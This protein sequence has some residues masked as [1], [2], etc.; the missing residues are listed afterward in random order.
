MNDLS[1]DL[2]VVKKENFKKL[3]ELSPEVIL[4]FPDGI[5]KA[6][7]SIWEQYLIDSPFKVAIVAKHHD[8]KDISNIRIPM[9]FNN[10]GV[11]PAQL[12]KIPSIKVF[13]YPTNRA[14]NFNYL[15]KFPHIKHVFIGH[16]DSD[17]LSSSSRFSTVYDF[18]FTADDNAATRFFE[19]G[20]KIPHERFITIGAPVV[21][22]LVVNTEKTVSIKNIL[23]APTSEGKAADSN[24]SSLM[25][26]NPAETLENL[27]LSFN[28]DYRPHPGAGERLPE[29]KSLSKVLKLLYSKNLSKEQSYNNA[30]LIICDISGVMSEF[31][32]TN[33]PIILPYNPKSK[34]I[35]ENINKS[36]FKE[37]VYLFDISKDNLHELISKISQ[38]DHLREAR[39]KA[40]NAKF[41][42]AMS[43]H[44]AAKN[45]SN[46][47]QYVLNN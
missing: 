20:V 2:Q 31:L 4:I 19:R 9:F 47:I 35:T 12:L 38:N 45:F 29:Y 13:L 15:N 27:S 11:G 26:I 6:W 23:F 30:D 43:F 28:I 18:L 46:A 42:G 1:T 24:F 14:N 3:Q 33:K 37:Y 41:L 40:R 8:K 25:E 32:F 10:T 7:V 17:K 21:P 16:G 22:G 44:E 34:L 39:E 5:S 36:E